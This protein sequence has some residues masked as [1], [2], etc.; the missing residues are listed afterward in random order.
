M[1]SLGYSATQEDLQRMIKEGDEDGDGFIDFNEFVHLN[2]HEVD[3]S[4]ILDDL[5]TAFMIIDVDGN[6]SI[7]PQDLQKLMK[8]LGQTYSMAECLKMIKGVDGNRDGKINF[9]EFKLMMM[10]SQ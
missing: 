4:K 3:S 5:L 9:Q 10:A 6:G 2:T 1:E 8:S 7:S